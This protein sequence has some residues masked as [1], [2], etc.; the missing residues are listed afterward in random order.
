[1]AEEGNGEKRL[2]KSEEERRE[3]QGA[4]DSRVLVEQ[5]KGIIAALA[6]VTPD[7]AFFR[8]RHWARDHNETVRDVCLEIVT[9][10]NSLARWSRD[11]RHNE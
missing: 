2:A 8:I 5:A 7:E 4:L 6:H 9:S 11:P 3:L 10:N 1:M